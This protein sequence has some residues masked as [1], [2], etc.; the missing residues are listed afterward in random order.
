MNSITPAAVAA[1]EHA[2]H[3]DGKFGTQHHSAPEPEL[4]PGVLVSMS[5]H[6]VRDAVAAMERSI[7]ALETRE[8]AMRIVAAAVSSNAAPQQLRVRGG[9]P[10]PEYANREE[11]PAFAAL[12]AQ[13]YQ[14]GLEDGTHPVVV[15]ECVPGQ[16]RVLL[17]GRQVGDVVAFDRHRPELDLRSQLVEMERDLE[18]GYETLE[19][20]SMVE[21][22]ET[23]PDWA[24]NGEVRF[25]RGD[26]DGV[27]VLVADDGTL[28]PSEVADV[29]PT[30]E[31]D[32]VRI[33]RTGGDYEIES[34]G[35]SDGT[36]WESHTPVWVGGIPH[37]W[38]DRPPF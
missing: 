15:E 12:S 4:T 30:T 8:R 33:A 9:R 18:I 20:L 14:W 23:H 5:A 1:R 34:A 28:A 36:Q 38:A 13:A 17:A 35:S 37:R 11:V 3:A 19:Q 27:P 24:A 32:W 22:L 29:F 31:T 16:Y 25:T 10:V 2:R 7:M 6:R 21:V 26:R